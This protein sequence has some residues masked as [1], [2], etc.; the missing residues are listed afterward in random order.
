MF[1]ASIDYVYQQ[2]VDTWTEIVGGS[3]G[4]STPAEKL[5]AY[6]A[7]H[8]G[9]GGLYRL[10]FAGL[11]ETDDPDVHEALKNMYGRFHRFIQTQIADHQGVKT[12]GRADLYA[13]AFV[14]LATVVNIGKELGLMG[15][16]KRKELFGKVGQ[17]FLDSGIE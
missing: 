6:E 15:V 11:N 5:L 10:I 8:Y 4:G 2:S 17:M 14:G 3:G 9:E 16:R 13:W 7:E 1:V 12:S